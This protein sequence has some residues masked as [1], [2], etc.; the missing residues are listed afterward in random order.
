MSE[1]LQAELDR[2]Q[3]RA[4]ALR[5]AVLKPRK[6]NGFH[7]AVLIEHLTGKNECFVFWPRDPGWEPHITYHEGGQFHAKSRGAGLTRSEKKSTPLRQTLNTF[8][9]TV[10]IGNFAGYSAQIPKCNP[11]DFDGS[12]TVQLSDLERDSVMVHLVEP[13][14]SLSAEDYGSYEVLREE[15]YRR[16]VPWLVVT[17]VRWKGIST[18]ARMKAPS[19]GGEIQKVQQS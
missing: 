1:D 10:H 11:A 19:N 3:I 8:K 7:Y 16:A 13:D 6:A 5:G 14:L 4:E 12:I 17:V 2:A 15:T 18:Q 9:G